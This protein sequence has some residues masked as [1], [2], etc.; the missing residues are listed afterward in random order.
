MGT[1]LRAEVEAATPQAARAALES[2]VS[3]VERFDR[4]L[5]TWDPRTPLSALNR[6]PVGEPVVVEPTLLSLLVE[7]EAWAHRT[8]RAFD[9]TVGPLVDAWDLR[10]QGRIPDHDELAGALAAVGL[11]GVALDPSSGTFTRRA[12]SAW[13]DSGAFGKGAALRAAAYTLRTGNAIRAL[14]DLGG[15][16]LAL[17]ESNDDAWRVAVAHPSRR[18]DAAAWLRLA[19][20]SAATSGNSE[21]G[22][23]V[24]GHRLGHLL[25]PRTG[26]PAPSWGSVTVV[27]ADPLVAD[28]LSTA[29]YVM[30]PEA[31][32]AWAEA[33]P[34]VGVLFLVETGGEVQALHNQAMRPWLLP[35]PGS[36]A[37]RE[38]SSPERRFP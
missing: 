21:R 6:A 30:G 28:I 4:Q 19:N 7:V 24:D 27:T 8:G 18:H 14:L 33:L 12:V 11:D 2:A 10:G 37:V 9:P 3:E 17:S 22:I 23:V 15:Q 16:I 34:D 26:L 1:L 31:G 29:L 38:P 32:L 5:S 13:I 35:P 25:D 36:A 20:V